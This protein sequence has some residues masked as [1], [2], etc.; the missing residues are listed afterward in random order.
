[1]MN[2]LYDSK[3][4]VGR[5]PECEEAEKEDCDRIF[6]ARYEFDRIMIQK[7][8]LDNRKKNVGTFC[9]LTP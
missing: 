1:M 8:M 7:I 9:V 5:A 2:L 6:E 3:F 4:F